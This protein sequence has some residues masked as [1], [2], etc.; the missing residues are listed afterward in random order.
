MDIY[1]NVRM[2]IHTHMH[3][4]DTQ[5][6]RKMENVFSVHGP[7]ERTQRYPETSPDPKEVEWSWLRHHFLP[8]T[9]S[10]NAFSG[11]ADLLVCCAVSQ[12]RPFHPPQMNRNWSVDKLEESDWNSGLKLTVNKNVLMSG[13][14]EGHWRVW[15]AGIALSQQSSIT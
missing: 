7:P 8:S 5:F 10:C 9:V 3:I 4:P 6:R 2:C 13:W 12:S 15:T 14:V 11:V 1:T